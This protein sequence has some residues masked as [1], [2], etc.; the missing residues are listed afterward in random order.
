MNFIP[1]V[2]SSIPSSR[3]TSLLITK[4]TKHANKHYDKNN[5]KKADARNAF[6]KLTRAVFSKE[7][8]E[9]RL[10]NVRQNVIDRG[11]KPEYR[12]NRNTKWRYDHQSLE[13]IEI[14]FS[15]AG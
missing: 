6:Q 12:I 14:I 9:N 7:V 15:N 1:G 13:K 3:S 8:R 10:N 4:K 11:K 5:N 2:R